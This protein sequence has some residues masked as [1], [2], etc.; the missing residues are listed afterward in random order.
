MTLETLFQTNPKLA[1]ALYVVLSDI[2]KLSSYCD[3]CLCEMCT[4]LKAAQS[5]LEQIETEVQVS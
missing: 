4:Y 2:M 5:M 3:D 1:I